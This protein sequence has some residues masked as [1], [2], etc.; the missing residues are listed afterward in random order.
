MLI[1]KNEE[2]TF[3]ELTN[4]LCMFERN[5]AKSETNHKNARETLAAK[6]QDKQKHNSKGTFQKQSRKGYTCSYCYKRG[7]W[8]EDCG[9]GFSMENRAEKDQRMYFMEH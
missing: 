4:Q 6:N 1:A 3:D 9:N 7:H 8:V 2:M 5:F